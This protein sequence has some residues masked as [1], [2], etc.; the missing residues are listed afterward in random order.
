AR[1]AAAVH[2]LRRLLRG[3]DDATR[4]RNRARADADEADREHDAA[5]EARAGADAARVAAAD[6]YGTAAESW[7][8]STVELR[9]PDAAAVVAAVCAWAADPDGASPLATAAE[10]AG[11][12]AAGALGA[13]DSRLADRSTVLHAERELV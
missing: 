10:Q 7:L 9:V 2:H 13:E 12:V 5:A 11:L 3:V 4:E 8:A 1:R 6:A